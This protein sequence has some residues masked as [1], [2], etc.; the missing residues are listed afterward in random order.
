MNFTDGSQVY[1]RDLGYR[2]DP[3]CLSR[4][5]PTDADR[6]FLKQIMRAVTEPG[7][8][9]AWIAPPSRG[10]NGQSVEFEYVR[11]LPA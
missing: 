8:I 10:I 3:E 4:W 7:K 1:R 6:E 2:Y 5:L 11:H 9:A